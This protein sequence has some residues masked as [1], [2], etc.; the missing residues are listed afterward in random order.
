MKSFTKN[1]P[2][3]LIPFKT[4]SIHVILKS[5][6]ILFSFLT[7]LCFSFAF[8]FSPPLSLKSA[9]HSP[10]FVVVLPSDSDQKLADRLP[11]EAHK[12]AFK[13][14]MSFLSHMLSYMDEVISHQEFSIQDYSPLFAAVND[15]GNESSGKEIYIDIKFD[16][17][18]NTNA[19]QFKK[20]IEG[21]FP[22]STIL[23]RQAFFT[24]LIDRHYA[25]SKSAYI[26]GF[27]MFFALCL[28]LL[29]IMNGA[30]TNHKHTIQTL[31]YLGSLRQ[32]L[33]H[34]FIS[35]F[36]SQFLYGVTIGLCLALI[37]FSV[38]VWSF[39]PGMQNP[40]VFLFQMGSLVALSAICYLCLRF[41]VYMMVNVRLKN[42]P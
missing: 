23:D 4:G 34:Q 35:F 3:T 1:V 2:L 22:G 24:D 32:T 13:D 31:R 21:I 6:F 41:F 16:H 33:S 19:V 7:L 26:T 29:V 10:G 28:S 8:L 9:S 17:N 39:N 25:L 20:D 40:S 30:F 36:R 42:L 27:F 5:I 12:A 18:H 15:T 37:C 14:A 38:L 11:H